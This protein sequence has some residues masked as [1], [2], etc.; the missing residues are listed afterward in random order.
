MEPILA[1][2]SEAVGSAHTLEELTR[3][4]LEM[5]EAVTGCESTYLTSIDWPGGLQHVRVAR[6]SRSD[7]LDIPEGLAVPWADTL[8]K[9]ALDEGRPYTNNVAECWGD[10]GAARELGIRTY[11]S[12]PVRAEDGHVHGTLCA[13]SAAAQP[14]SAQ[15]QHVLELF[16]RLINQH[17]ERE[18]LVA[19]LQAVNAQL[20]ASSLTDQ[21]TGLP[22]RRRLIEEL[23][24]LIGRSARAETSVLVAFIDL[25]GFKAVNDTHGHQSGDA[26]LRAIAGRLAGTLRG[27]DMLARL[28]GD[29]FVVIGPGPGL[30]EDASAAV[31]ALGQRLGDCTVGDFDLGT[32]CIA[33]AGASVGAVAVDPRH[34]SA[35]HALRQADAAMYERKRARAAGRP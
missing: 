20:A 6:N 9:R 29:E 3:P 28:G 4:L 11:M 27:G 21:L 13:A 32:Q 35:D 31:V 24:G 14:M 15:S 17:L 12:T 19:E 5:L 2:L 26:F 10:S 34:C 8:C 22:N 7:A 23:E 18:R 30:G 25:D 1:Q 16:S 33:Y